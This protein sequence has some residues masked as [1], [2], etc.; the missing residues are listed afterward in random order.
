M[1]QVHPS[2]GYKEGDRVMVWNQAYRYMTKPTQSLWIDHS[3]FISPL[4]GMYVFLLHQMAPKSLSLF[5]FTSSSLI[6]QESL[7][8]LITPLLFLVHK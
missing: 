2:Q 7:N 1:L 4:K 3:Q 5:T 8:H 6:I